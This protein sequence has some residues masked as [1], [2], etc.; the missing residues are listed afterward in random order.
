[1]KKQ[2]PKSVTRLQRWIPDVS[3]L[4]LNPIRN[5]SPTVLVTLSKMRSDHWRITAEKIGYIKII[6]EAV[7]RLQRTI[8]E[9]KIQAQL[10]SKRARK[11]LTASRY[12][13]A[14]GAIHS[15]SGTIK[16][17]EHGPTSA[18]RLAKSVSSCY[19]KSI[20]WFNK[21][22]KLLIPEINDA[23][24]IKQNDQLLHEA[25]EF[26]P[27]RAI[28]KWRHLLN[29]AE[30]RAKCRHAI[31]MITI[32]HKSF[33]SIY[34][35]YV[36]QSLGVQFDSAEN[37]IGNINSMISELAVNG[38]NMLNRRRTFAKALSRVKNK[39]F[40]LEGLTQTAKTKA[41][42]IATR[43]VPLSECRQLSLKN[44]MLTATHYLMKLTNEKLRSSNTNSDLVKVLQMLTRQHAHISK[45]ETVSLSL[46]SVTQNNYQS[47]WNYS[48]AAANIE[49]ARSIIA[50]KPVCIPESSANNQASLHVAAL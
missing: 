37:T 46:P 16:Y 2:S 33:L 34:L 25:E 40:E 24:A 39:L 9:L 1:M 32:H 48:I 43:Q 31:T 11:Q 14:V 45:C 22:K 49:I 3:I 12:K 19:M 20:L 42:Y 4:D 38:P 29:S 6:Y 28:P 10:S 41:P 13:Y 18:K 36:T 44:R 17:I 21:A 8:D 15:I 30:T 26:L 50:A 27:K 35:N 5:W 47:R 23:I 7:G